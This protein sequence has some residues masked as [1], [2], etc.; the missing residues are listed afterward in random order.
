MQNK[1]IAAIVVLGIICLIVAI[2]YSI[3]TKTQTIVSSNTIN[4][5]NLTLTINSTAI[6]QNGNLS[7]D[8]KLVNTLD[9]YINITAENNWPDI[10]GLELPYT[11]PGQICTG[12]GILAGA[13]RLSLFKGYYTTGNISSANNPMALAAP[14]TRENLPIPSCPTSLGFHYIPLTYS[15]KPLSDEAILLVNKT[16]YNER[17]KNITTFNETIEYSMNAIGYTAPRSLGPAYNFTSGI[18]TLVGADEWNQ[19]AIVHFNVTGAMTMQS[20]NSSVYNDFNLSIN[21]NTTSGVAIANAGLFY[22]GSDGYA[23]NTSKTEGDFYTY[24]GYASPD[25]LNCNGYPYSTFGI[26]LYSGYYNWGTITSASPLGQYN[27]TILYLPCAIRLA[28]LGPVGAFDPKS[29]NVTL[30]Y[31]TQSYRNGTNVS[32]QQNV[33]YPQ[34]LTLNLTGYWTAAGNNYTFHTLQPGA[35]TVEAVDIFNQTAIVHFYVTSAT[36]MPP[37]NSSV[38]GDFNLSISVNT[39]NATASGVSIS[40][41][42]FYNGSSSY[43]LN[44]TKTPELGNAQV[45]TVPS[46]WP[47]V[48]NTFKLLGIKVYAG[49]YT[50]NNI[51][52][53]TPL[54]LYYSCENCVIACPT[55]GGPASSIIFNPNSANVTFTS[56]QTVQQEVT[57]DF[58]G[59]WSEG[60]YLDESRNFKNSTLEKLTPGYYTAEAIDSFNQTAIV[61]FH[62]D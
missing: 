60:G 7:I 24:V 32:S 8:L 46:W 10:K 44:A 12:S 56:T 43:T 35:Y 16:N 34:K 27:A 47:C 52:N 59:Y 2:N 4:G 57:L 21:V 18:Y 40:T 62:I 20:S 41:R 1:I 33:S 19:T 29:H 54:N 30:T 55:L 45:Y 53:A 50:A 13:I 3:N 37:S 49:Y 28:R 11:Q 61:H 9:S 58:K 36:V 14:F 23:I 15:F 5:L 25:T 31:V 26:R 6:S 48:E 42:L 38:R 22:N 39:T 51:N 17:G